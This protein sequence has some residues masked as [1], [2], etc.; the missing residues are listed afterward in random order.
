MGILSSSFLSITR[1]T[2]PIMEP[3]A[4]ARENRARRVARRRGYQIKKCPRHDPL[5]RGYGTFCIFNDA[6]RIVAGDYAWYG[7]T[8]GEVEEWLDQP[9]KEGF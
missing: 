3:A 2:I 8:I 9:R 1:G 5:S 7:M 4:K 6:G